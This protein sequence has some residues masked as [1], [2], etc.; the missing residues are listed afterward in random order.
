[1]TTNLP[2][3]A[4]GRPRAFD[5]DEALNVAL[6]LFRRKGFDNTSLE[7]LTQALQVN[8][9]SLYAAFG[10]KEQLF[11]EILQAYTSGPTAYFNAVFDEPTTKAL[12]KTL[13]TKSVEVLFYSEAP[14]GCLV[15]M[16]TASA[17]LQKAG[18]QQRLIAS[19]QAHQHKLRERFEQAK[20][21]GELK[22]GINAVR[23]A[24]Y[25]VTLHKGLSLQAINGS[26]KDELLQLVEQV[27]ELWPTTA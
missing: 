14:F 3:R 4:R 5:R 1:M 26:S 10:N 21:N 7:D 27:L 8:K 22:A 2:K 20:L 23:L 13:L 18:I 19:L 9:P 15:V 12:V 17:E 24:T 16:S 11:L 25:L 6:D